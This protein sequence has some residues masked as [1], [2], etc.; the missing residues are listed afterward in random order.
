MEIIFRFSWRQFL[1][2]LNNSIFLL[3]AISDVE[4]KLRESCDEGSEDGR[5][6]HDIFRKERGRGSGILFVSMENE[7]DFILHLLQ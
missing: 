6:V 4:P 3:S 7:M 1:S 5:N 2:L